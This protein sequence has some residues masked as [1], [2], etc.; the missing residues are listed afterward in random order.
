QP[1]NDRRRRSLC[2]S[3]R[4][5]VDVVAVSRVLRLAESLQ[6]LGRDRSEQSGL[7]EHFDAKS[8]PRGKQQLGEFFAD[9]FRGDS[10]KRVQVLRDRFA[11][12]W[13][14]LEVEH[15]SEPHRAQRPKPVFGETRARVPD[16]T[17][18]A[19]LEIQAAIEGIAEAV[20]DRIEGHRV[21]GEIP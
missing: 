3:K 6:N 19:A 13:I 17:Y 11:G 12:R 16:A 9:S 10:S 5:A 18:P 21:D 1:Q 14:Q 8:N 2:G 4:V 20:S 15:G 7:A